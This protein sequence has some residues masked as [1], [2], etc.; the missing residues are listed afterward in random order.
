MQTVR[1]ESI[2][3]VTYPVMHQPMGLAVLLREATA[4]KDLTPFG[5]SLL[6]RIAKH[7]DPHALLDLSLILQL[8]YQREAAISVQTQAIAMCRHYR[9]KDASATGRPRVLMLKA[10]GDLMVN[11]PIECL[12][13]NADLQLD[14][15]Y[16]DAQLPDVGLPEH[17]VIFVAPCASDETAVVLEQIA[18]LVERTNRPVLNRPHRIALTARDEAYALLEKVHGIAMAHT[19]RLSRERVVEAAHGLFDLSAVVDGRYPF[20]IRPRGS[21]AGQGLA[22]VADSGELAD[23]LNASDASEFYLAP[24]IDYRSRDGLFRK[25]RIVMIDGQPFVCHMGIS[26]EWMVHYPYAEMLLHAERR[27]EEADVMASFDHDFAARHTVALRMIVELTGL[28]YVGFDCAET[29]DGRLLIFETATA[30]VVH[31]MDDPEHFPYKLPQMRRVFDAF[32]QMLYRAAAK[33]CLT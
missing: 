30:M 26:K 23:Y 25:Y 28:D 29:S 6:E 31:D 11:S 5:Q 8:K 1:T 4:G 7:A 9:L 33:P 14:V 20:I 10:P 12:L 3:D 21:H 15:L 32:A 19:V 2:D 24:F 22:R 13:E 27:Q 17:D 16:V 18:S